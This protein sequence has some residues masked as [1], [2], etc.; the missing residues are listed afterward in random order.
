MKVGFYYTLSSASV[1][2]YR[3]LNPLTL[4]SF[5][6]LMVVGGSSQVGGS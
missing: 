1:T 2:A 5:L 6:G 3:H 4:M